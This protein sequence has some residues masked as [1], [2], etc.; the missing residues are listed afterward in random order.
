MSPEPASPSG[1][2]SIPGS[3]VAALATGSGGAGAHAAAHGAGL[4]HM[5]GRVGMICFLCSEAAFFSTLVLAYITFIGK[6]KSGPT[7]ATALELTI[8]IIGTVCLL[9]SSATIGMAVK[10]LRDGS[11][12]LAAYWL[13]ATVLLGAGFLCGT[14]FEWAELIGRYGLTPG[15]NLFGTTYFTL[16]GFHAAHVSI[17][18]LVMLAALLMVEREAIRAAMCEGLELV[19]WYWHFVDGVWVVIFTVVYL[20]GR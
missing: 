11:G 5:R 2:A 13:V 10:K 12:R 7:P 20:L 15:R 14:G 6:S 9:S 18:L 1:L 17:G 3:S 19:A 4:E 16:I 8:P